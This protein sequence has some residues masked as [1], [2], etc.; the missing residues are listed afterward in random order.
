MVFGRLEPVRELMLKNSNPP[1]NE[2]SDA[3]GGPFHLASDADFF[4]VTQAQPCPYLPDRAERK[5]VARLEGDAPAQHDRLAQAGFRRIRDFVYRPACAGCRACLPI[6]VIAREFH[7]NGS[8]R[9]NE[10]RNADLIGVE[11]PLAARPHHFDLFRRYQDARHAEGDMASMDFTE[12][13]AMIEDSP[14]DTRMIEFRDGDGK[15]VAASLTDRLSD[16]L[17][18]VYEFFD[19]DESHRSPGTFAILWHIREA[20]RLGLPYV[21]LGYWIASSPKMAYKDRFRPFEFLLD[22]R[23]QRQD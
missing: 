7:P 22:G 14:L 18:A 2:L 21:Y 23:W 3:A 13:R 9:R 19:P 11:A 17:S 20:Q 6:R 1:P 5:I 16:G 15:I 12:Y 10:R 8:F 4:Y